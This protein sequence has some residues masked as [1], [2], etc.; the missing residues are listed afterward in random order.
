[1]Q[2]YLRHLRPHG[3]IA[4]HI[5]NLH[6]DLRRV[7]DALAVASN[8]HAITLETV[9]VMD[10]DTDTQS[11]IDPGSRWV[12]LARDPELL[13]RRRYA[14]IAARAPLPDERHVLWT[15]DFSN[16]IEVLDW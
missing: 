8:L 2:S 15:D 10:P 3:L 16:L 11:L 9:P 14:E 1:M 6:F 4:I 13:N 7:T 5:S 12:L